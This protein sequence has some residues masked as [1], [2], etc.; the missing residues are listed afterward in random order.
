MNYK[1]GSYLS[2][3]ILDSKEL[4]DGMLVQK[5]EKL[6][7]SPP[8]LFCVQCTNTYAIIFFLEKTLLCDINY[9]MYH[10]QQSMFV[11]EAA[12]LNT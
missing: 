11:S 1:R 4:L 10:L 9:L 12:A 7:S 2:W 5:T 8:S 6:G 3:T